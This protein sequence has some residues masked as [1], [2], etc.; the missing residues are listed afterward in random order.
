MRNHGLVNRNKNL[1]FGYNSRLDTIQAVVANHLL[2]KLKFLTNK[3]IS[4][5][6]YLDAKLKKIKDLELIKREKNDIEV[7]HLYCLR[8]KTKRNKIIRELQKKNI[9]V[10]IHYPVPMHLQPAAKNMGYKKGDFPITEKIAKETISLP[11]HEF[12]TKKNLDKIIEIFNRIYE[13]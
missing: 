1:L 12:I 6:R 9:D 8:I 10:K 4:N 2:K 3:R 5:A 7:F 11:I 13:K